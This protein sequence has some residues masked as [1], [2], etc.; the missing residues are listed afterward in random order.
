MEGIEKDLGRMSK[1]LLSREVA[2]SVGLASSGIREALNYLAIVK[3][4]IKKT[5]RAVAK[6]NSASDSATLPTGEL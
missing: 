3:K 2:Q 6:K 4:V 1:R 5:E